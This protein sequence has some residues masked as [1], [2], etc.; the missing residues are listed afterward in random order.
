MKVSYKWLKE[1]LPIKLTPEEIADYLTSTGLEVEGVN[2]YQ[3]LR[4]NLKGVV[5]GE[6]V[7]CER[8]PNADRLTVCKVYVGNNKNFFIVCGA[9]NVKSGQKVLVAKIGS[10]IYPK[11]SKSGI[12]IK[13]T[14]IRGVSSEGMICAEDELGIGD[15]HDGIM[16]MPDN[17]IPGT[18]ASEL[19]NNYTDTVLEIGITP[20]RTDALSHIGVARDLM[21]AFSFRNKMNVSYTVP[22]YERIKSAKR[23]LPV[24]IEITNNSQCKRYSGVVLRNVSVGK[25]PDWLQ[26]RLQAI[27]IKPHNNVVDVTNYV[28]H[29]LGHPLHAFD[30]DRVEN[31]HIIVKNLKDG[32]P[33]ITL[34]GIERTLSEND[35]MICDPVK[36]LC[37]A[38]V[39]GGITSGVTDETRH[40]FLESA[41][42]DPLSIRRSAKR[43][44]LQTD[45]SFRFER[46]ADIGITIKVLK[47]AAGLLCEIA[48]ADVSSDFIDTGQWIKEKQE[49]LISISYD[50]VKKVMGLKITK[51]DIKKILNLLEFELKNEDAEELQVIAPDYR[52]DVTREIDV[53]E[54]IIRIYGMDNIITPKKL[55]VSFPHQIN[56]NK[57]KLQDKITQYL[58]SNGFFQAWNNS[59]I[60]SKANSFVVENNR[61]QTDVIIL[62]PLSQDLN[63]LRRSL[64]PGM[65]QMAN[66][67]INRKTESIKAFEIGAVYKKIKSTQVTEPVTDQY[68]EKNVLAI[69]MTGYYNNESW[70]DEHKPIGFYNIKHYTDNILRMTGVEMIDVEVEVK[71]HLPFSSSVIY[72]VN[73]KVILQ[74]GEVKKNILGK[75]S[76]K[77][78]LLYAEFDL[79]N[80][81]ELNR[82]NIVKCKPLPKFPEVRRDLSLI[83]DQNVNFVD[84][85][86]I[87]LNADKKVVKDVF[88][89]D[90]YQDPKIPKKKKSYAVG[91][92][93]QD[94]TK[95]LSDKEI[96]SLMIKIINCLGEDLGAELRA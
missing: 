29:E 68:N 42:F 86:N 19:F 32:T 52:Y 47:R 50:K 60:S 46:G 92:I 67:N 87:I 36:P 22:K 76:I 14:M 8:H 40:V 83:I 53:I 74:F 78:P 49:R 38:G 41:W 18:E 16:V 48:N 6:I 64:L 45:A 21:A 70:F 88:L 15:S 31:G 12:I 89:F 81:I 73:D 39:Y 34:D 9:S 7:W 71:N 59:L 65:L 54:E 43:H 95:T 2:S 57:N 28:M 82:N 1:F 44:M 55:N 11:G 93:L 69:V 84:I 66:Y 35:L 13:K 63:A 24:K 79:E 91:I 85:K 33:F 30:Y 26:N 94:E 23:K 51:S 90:I 20:N 10:T 72:K 96:E 58:I 80:L 61:E 4:G 5:V 77:Q 37:I 3:R 56:I 62:N 17:S 25:S 75:F 27:G